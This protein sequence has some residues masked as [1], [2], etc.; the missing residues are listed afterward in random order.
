M[1]DRMMKVIFLPKQGKP[2]YTKPSA[3]RRNTISSDCGKIVEGLLDARLRCLFRISKAIDAEPKDIQS[4]RSTVRLLDR[5]KLCC[6][7]VN[8]NLQK[9][10][11]ISIDFENAFDSVWINGLLSKRHLSGV[12]GKLM[13]LI[14]DILKNRHLSTQ[15][16]YEDGEL[17][18][19]RIGLPQGS[20]IC[21]IIFVFIFVSVTCSTG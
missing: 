5:L 1:E 7:E 19:K 16:G 14:A 8:R 4:H 18:G 20:V 2:D 13:K 10:A 9:G 6:Q 15:I 11:V 17:F 3:C 21:P 12:K